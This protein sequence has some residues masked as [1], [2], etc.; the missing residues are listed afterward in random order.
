MQKTAE[1]PT[2]TTP[3]VL[4]VPDRPS[5]QTGWRSP[6]SDWRIEYSWPACPRSAPPSGDLADKRVEP[7]PAALVRITGNTFRFATPA[8]RQV[9]RAATARSARGSDGRPPAD[10]R[11]DSCRTPSG[12]RRPAG[13]GDA[14]RA[15]NA[16]PRTAP[17]RNGEIRKR[18]P[19]HNLLG[20][21]ITEVAL[22]SS[23][24]AGP[25]RPGHAAG[26]CG[27]G[28]AVAA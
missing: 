27:G 25:G 3:S 18:I 19:E 7:Y 22:W 9:G 10:G 11:T 2:P 15:A 8:S 21:A 6:L 4:T 5:Q 12:P 26:S 20:P 28:A 24:A 13:H 23:A 14:S 1:P 17:H 16:T